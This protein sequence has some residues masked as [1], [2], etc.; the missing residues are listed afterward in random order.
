M[1]NYHHFIRSILVFLCFSCFCPQVPGKEAHY[2]APDEIFMQCKKIEHQHKDWAT[3]H[4]LGKTSGGRDIFLMELGH[5][6]K[7]LPAIFI[8]ANMEGDCPLASEAAMELMELLLDDWQEE[9]KAHTWYIVPTGNPDGYAHFF[10]KPLFECF[11]ND[12]SFN[13][14][15]DDASDEDGPEDLNGDGYITMI[16]QP[17]PE[18]SWLKVEKNPVLMKQAQSSKGEKGEF[19]LFSEGIDNDGDG[20]YNEDRTGG[21][22]PGHNFP[23]N[24]QHYT[25]T[26]GP[27][28]ASE[29]ESRAVM[30]F[31]FDHPEIAMVLTFG[32]TNSLEQVPESSKKV[33]SVQQHYQLPEKIATQMG[34][35]PEKWFSMKEL[36]ALGQEYTGLQDISEEMVLQF[37]GLGLAVNPDP[38]DLLYWSAISKQYSEFMKKIGRD[39]ERLPPQKFSPGAIEEWAY[40]HYGVPSFSLD[41][42]T[43]PLQKKNQDKSK[44]TMPF[45]QIKT[46]TKEEF[47]ALGK[48][49]IGQLLKESGAPAQYTA[50]IVIDA[51]QAG[52]LST[53]QI[54]EI[55]TQARQKD[56]ASGADGTEQALFEFNPDAFIPWQPFN[57][58]TLGN[59]EIGG[60]IPYTNLAPLTAEMQE[61]VR[62][63]LPFIRELVT[64]LP[65][66]AIDKIKLEKKEKH[67]WKLE[68]WIV[69]RG[70]L[71]YPTHQGKRCRRPRPVIVTLKGKAVTFL[72]GKER[73][74]LD[75]MA[76]SGGTQKVSW[77]LQAKERST[78]SLKVHCF[79]ATDE[80]RQL[81]L[82]EGGQP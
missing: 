6:K 46:M 38:Q 12:R 42:W 74:V 28:A 23:H 11:V 44:D 73:Q 33:K 55:L 35:N 3:L 27:W 59:V 10:E 77:L 79:S 39:A 52:H 65:Q 19:R 71:P 48:E 16:R 43:I 1:T 68:T 56:E 75:L 7:T 81:T 50:D 70:F 63:Q 69:N 2:R 25:K 20:K 51:L 53:T 80:E 58:P 32:R 72:E 61:L 14:D 5:Q 31:A 22:N 76:G 82:I 47:M 13:D 17:H 24:F 9:L 45:G 64:L 29:T 66:F 26:D 34:L 21:V 37:L 18:G 4:L 30:R 62:T 36:I 49:K 67:I 60:K 78:V 41:F 57:H 54:V 40:F 15:N 8:V